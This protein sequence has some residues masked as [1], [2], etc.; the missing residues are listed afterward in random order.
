MNLS[1]TV[2]IPTHVMAREV[3]DE[4]VVLDLAGGAYYGLDAVGVRIWQLL[5]DGKSLAEVCETLLEEFDVARDVLETDLLRL[6]GE[7]R[8]KKLVLV[9]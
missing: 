2:T 5:G 7:L 6:L 3:G 1:D 9:S 8:D 4:I